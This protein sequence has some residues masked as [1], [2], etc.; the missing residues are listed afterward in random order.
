MNGG[1]STKD[2]FVVKSPKVLMEKA[3]VVA[4]APLPVNLKCHSVL[5]GT[6]DY[7]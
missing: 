6:S 4:V 2:L 1:F 7:G 5:S 3:P